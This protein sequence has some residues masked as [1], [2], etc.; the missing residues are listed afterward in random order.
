MLKKQFLL[1]SLCF[2]TLAGGPSYSK[3]NLGNSNSNYYQNQ[4]E[5]ISPP[6][7][8]NIWNSFDINDPNLPVKQSEFKAQTI[9]E[10]VEQANID[11]DNI[12]QPQKKFKP[13]ANDLTQA[14]DSSEIQN[15]IQNSGQPKPVDP[16]KLLRELQDPNAPK[17]KN[18]LLNG[19]DDPAGQNLE[20]RLPLDE[21]LS[22][23]FAN[24]ILD[25]IELDVDQADVL[26]LNIEKALLISLESNL[27]Q[28]IIDET[29]IRDKW[30][31]WT[32]TSGLLPDGFYSYSMNDQ[33]LS[34]GVSAAGTSL[35]AGTTHTTSLGARYNLAPSEVFSTLASYYDWMA[36]S[37]FQGAS[38]Q[39]L[40][41]R[42]VNQYYEVMRAR[43]ELAVR[44]EA[45]KQAKIQLE[46]NE[47]LE[48]AG[49]GTRFAVLQAREQL[50]ENQLAL[51]SQQSS[52]RIAEI[53]LL[54]TL[55]VPL[56][57][58]IRLE[59]SE[60]QR[61]TLISPDYSITELVDLAIT[62]RPDIR[63]R[64]LAVRAARHRVKQ[65]VASA[66][67]P[68]L[69]TT[70]SLFEQSRDFGDSFKLS[71]SRF[72]LG[73]DLPILTGMGLGLISP[74]N[75]SRAI[76][77]QTGLELENE[78]LN[79]EGEVRDAFL[80]SQASE[81]RIG[82]AEQQL[83]AATEGIKLA[84]IR[85][86]NGVGTNIDLID[87][88]RNYV[89]ALV[90]KVR[91][92]VEYNQA[93]VDILRSTGLISIDS[94]LNKDYFNKASDGTSDELENLEE[95]GFEDAGYSSQDV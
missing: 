19:S 29:V 65:S 67:A 22:E 81:K 95:D 85:L 47:K 48:Q 86:A 94:V 74:I 64:Q 11:K 71:E 44:I 68:S 43:G 45:V 57:T 26:Q 63:R 91:A 69:S 23:R 12:V 9:K 13:K 49:V 37:S 72:Q 32:T 33:S 41:R 6:E 2:I 34:G 18:S 82:V 10:Q 59:E 78:I 83:Q 62:N 35:S 15:N 31:F 36:N 7:E 17:P 16:F 1:A 3:E 51:L 58:D 87:T 14:V 54:T 25:P 76:S 55:N 4:N 92:I 5:N 28:R 70:A 39:D 8:N 79:I 80:R 24:D 46:L 56:G 84:R 93:Q 75:E 89:N 53:Q 77:R 27:P 40:M 21:P 42:T 66:F 50:A 61:S 38:L 90:N 88:Q 73:V 30:R 60:I 52:A 20:K